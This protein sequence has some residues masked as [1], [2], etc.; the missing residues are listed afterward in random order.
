MTLASLYTEEF[1]KY[2]QKY[3]VIYID[4]Y[5]DLEPTEAEKRFR[6]QLEIKK[7]WPFPIKPEI[8]TL[9]TH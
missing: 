1:K 9:V 5:N 6:F 4:R 8:R 7:K 2:D 3:D